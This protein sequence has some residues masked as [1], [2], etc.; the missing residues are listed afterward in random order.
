[1][2]YCLAVYVATL[3]NVGFQI[4]CLAILT[5]L[6]VIRIRFDK[7]SSNSIEMNNK[8]CMSLNIMMSWKQERDILFVFVWKLWFPLLQLIK[9]GVYFS[10]FV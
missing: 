5:L 7:L 6:S 1:M 10:V 3:S 2:S 8:K 9:P 4:D